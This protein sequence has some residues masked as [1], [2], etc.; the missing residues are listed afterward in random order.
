[1]ERKYRR[2]FAIVVDSFGIGAMPDSEKFGD[3]GVDTCGHI[4]EAVESFCI[5]NMQKL[6]LANLR[7]IKHVPAADRTMGY[8]AKLRETSNGKDTMTGHWEMMGI[9]TQ[10]PFITF[11][12]T[13][14]PK[15]LIEELEKRCGREVIGNKSASGTEILDELGEQEINEGKMIVYTSAEMRRLWALRISTNTVRLPES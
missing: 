11:T 12:D 6:G 8:Y 9:N 14:F 2:V 7:P 5:P 3:V 4:A 13:G 15:E 10:K 1:M